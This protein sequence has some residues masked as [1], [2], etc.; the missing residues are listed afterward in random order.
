VEIT[1]I[2]IDAEGHYVVEYVTHGFTEELPGTHLH[3]FFNNVTQ[4]EVGALGANR[5]MSG[6]PTPFRGY[7]T[8]DRPAEATQMC[9]VVANP[10]HSVILDSGNCLQLPDVTTPGKSCSHG[11][12][13][14]PQR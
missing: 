6:G 9:V 7:L 12:W 1:Q 14:P 4:A 2:T 13:V 8:A 3:F 5:R 11:S 10:D